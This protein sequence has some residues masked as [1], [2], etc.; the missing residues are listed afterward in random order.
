MANNIA[1]FKQYVPLLDEV[2]KNAS[3][4][5]VLDGSPE[6]VQQGANANELVIP[7]IEMDGLADYSRNSGYVDGDVTLTNQT[8]AC[9]YDRGRKFTVDT[10]DNEETAGIA[11]GRLSGEFIRTKVVPE[12]DAVRLSR[13]ASLDN[14]G[15]ASVTL[16]T[17]D[18][19]IKAL[20]AGTAKMDDDEVPQEERYLYIRNDLYGL[21]QDMDTTKSRQV[22]ERFAQIFPTPS[23]RLATKLTLNDG[24]TGGQEK[25]G[26]KK[27]SDAL[28]INFEI[29]HKPAVIQYTKHQSPKVIAPEV[30][31]DAD[32]WGFGY[33]IVG[34]SKGY[35]NK[36][37]GIYCH[38]APKSSS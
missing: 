19:V 22:L 18:A 4:T 36:R 12:L 37:S 29:I 23:S 31:P 15:T 26:Y 25:G 13:Y 11:F 28:D 33:R 21:I 7:M 20:R 10:L 34:I 30:N 9:D 2:Y 14:I 17:G 16:S 27:A 1:L 35:E 6:L 24:K 38:T 8:V 5:S 3:L 32:A